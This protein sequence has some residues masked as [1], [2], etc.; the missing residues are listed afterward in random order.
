M[1]WRK[2]GP[3]LQ[4]APGYV[5]VAQKVCSSSDLAILVHVEIN[6]LLAVQEKRL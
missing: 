1:R 5:G 3:V 4:K 6:M 2:I